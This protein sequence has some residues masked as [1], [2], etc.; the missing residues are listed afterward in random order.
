MALYFNNQ[1][2]AQ[3]ADVYFNNSACGAAYFNNALVWQK[4]KPIY[5]GTAA[6]FQNLSDYQP[7][8]TYSDDGAQACL[9][10]FGG[11][12]TGCVRAFFGPFPTAG[13]R[14]LYVTLS[15]SVTLDRQHYL[16]FG[17]APGLDGA[18]TLLYENAYD[19]PGIPGGTY[20][21]PVGSYG[22]AYFAIHQQ[23]A[24]N[25]TGHTC[26]TYIHNLYLQ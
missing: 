26:T 14:T 19:F 16:A 5:P 22:S 18:W 9:H 15:S 23:S 7:Y 3:S 12:N 11:T 4:R 13:F 21:Y 24:P 17:L 20:A 1:D 6:V 10:T 8:G 2:V 25:C